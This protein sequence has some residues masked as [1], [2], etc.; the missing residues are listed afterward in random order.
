MQNC[1]RRIEQ[2]AAFIPL[3]RLLLHPR[4]EAN[5]G[6]ARSSA[7]LYARRRSGQRCSLT[8]K[9]ARNAIVRRLG[10]TADRRE[11]YRKSRDH[12]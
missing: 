1:H 9:R 12:G 5:A 7:V 3:S 6:R 4:F 11:P 10:G 8:R 2:R